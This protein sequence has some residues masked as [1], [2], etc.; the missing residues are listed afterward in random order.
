M[1]EFA[2]KDLSASRSWDDDQF[3]IITMWSRS[4]LSKRC[5]PDGQVDLWR[6]GLGASDSALRQLR[7]LLSD[8]EAQRAERFRFPVLRRRFVAGRGALRTILSQYLP[9]RPECLEFAYGLHGKP[10][11]RNT[12][13]GIQFNLSHSDDLMVAAVCRNWPVG[14]DIE[15]ENP[16]FGALEIAERYFSGRERHEISNLEGEAR[17]RA[18]FQFWTAKEAVLKAVS[19]GLQ[20]ELSKLEIALRPLRILAFDD[21]ATT[22]GANWH[23]TAFRPSEGYSG[24]LAVAGQPTRVSYHQFDPLT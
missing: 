22:N 5:L 12:T 14:V 4:T 3:R 13:D 10:L 15:K 24:T 16:G 19:L 17:L 18:F 23:L 20:L 9:Q 7:G 8:E 6:V 2:R 21:P 1:D 11:L